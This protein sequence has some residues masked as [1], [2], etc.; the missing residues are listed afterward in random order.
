MQNR[1][2]TLP[3]DPGPGM[4]ASDLLALAGAVVALLAEA[5][6]ASSVDVALT[7]DNS[8]LFY[9]GVR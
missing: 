5:S 7:L 2:I 4:G 6:G 9:E 1:I 8:S 3:A